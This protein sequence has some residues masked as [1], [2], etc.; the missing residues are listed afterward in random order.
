ML[1]PRPARLGLTRCLKLFC[2]NNLLGGA[3]SPFRQ[4]RNGL[5]KE[6]T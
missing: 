1:R 4:A 2:L 6:E 5:S 3:E